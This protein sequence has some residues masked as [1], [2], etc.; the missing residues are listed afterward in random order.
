MTQG[1]MFIHR[2]D[3][4]DSGYNFNYSSV[5]TDVFKEVY[6]RSGGSSPTFFSGD[7]IAQFGV[8]IGLLISILIIAVLI[9]FARRIDRYEGNKR[10]IEWSFFCII[11]LLGNAGIHESFILRA[12]ALA[13]NVIVLFIIDNSIKMNCK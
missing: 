2:I 8:I 7:F 4:I 3:M 1:A 9:Y 10:Y 5:S 11:Y 13:F 12:I 6:G